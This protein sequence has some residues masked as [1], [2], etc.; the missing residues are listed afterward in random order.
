MT[1]I[2]ACIVPL[3]GPPGWCSGGALFVLGLMV[4][5]DN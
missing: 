4:L 3:G 1:V 2:A 5:A